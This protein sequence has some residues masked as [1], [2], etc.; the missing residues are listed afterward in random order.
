MTRLTAVS[1]LNIPE[2]LKFAFVGV[3]NTA[4]DIA[5]LN[6]L[7]ILFG[8]GRHNSLYVLFKAFSFL[9]ATANSYFLNNYFVF[10]SKNNSRDNESLIFFLVSFAG[11]LL[12][13]VAS[14]ILFSSLIRF[15]KVSIN[16]ATNIGA[17][18]GSA[19]VFLWNFIGY[20]FIVF[21]NQHE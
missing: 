7:V 15:N 18:V 4:I 6:L 11:F 14:S 9:V 1:R 2:L 5:L 12:N 16:L 3:I 21:K 20:K 13:V 17:F 10:S 19:T 8:T